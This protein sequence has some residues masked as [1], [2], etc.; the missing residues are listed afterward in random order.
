VLT[1]NHTVEDPYAHAY[2]YYIR[3]ISRYDRLWNGVAQ[4]PA[5]YRDQNNALESSTISKSLAN[6]RYTPTPLPGGLDFVL[7]RIQPL[8]EPTLL[9]SGRLD[10]PRPGGGVQPA[11][12]GRYWQV[13]VG[14]HPEQALTERNITMARMLAYRQIAWTLVREI[15]PGD[16][17]TQQDIQTLLKVT[18]DLQSTHNVSD[19][20]LPGDPPVP[21]QFAEP[22]AGSNDALEVQLA[23]RLSRFG[24]GALVLSW[25]ALPYYY[26]HRLL[27]IAQAANVVSNIVDVTQVAF[28]YVSPVPRTLIDGQTRGS[29]TT[30]RIRRIRI[31]LENYW[32]CLPSSARTPADGAP[33]TRETPTQ[34][35]WA[36]ENPYRIVL[37]FTF[38][39]SEDH[40]DPAAL[41]AV[42]GKRA[43]IDLST[44]PAT[45][46][47]DQYHLNKDESDALDAWRTDP[48]FSAEFKQRV[49]DLLDQLRNRPHR[50]FSSLVDPA[51][52]YQL[53]LS[54]PG[55]VVQVLADFRYQPA[56]VP[57]SVPVAAGF[58][59]RNFPTTFSTA[60]WEAATVGYLPYDTDPASPLDAYL[61][62][63]LGPKTPQSDTW[64][65]TRGVSSRHDLV[66]T[67]TPP[68]R[69]SFLSKTFPLDALLIGVY[70]ADKPLSATDVD[71]LR[72]ALL[73]A[74]RDTAFK[75]AVERVCTRLLAGERTFEEPVSV[76]LEALRELS[77]DA[78]LPTEA[79][80]KLTWTGKIE[81]DNR[82]MIE[83][84]RD[85][86]SPFAATLT[87]LLDAYDNPAVEFVPTGAHPVQSDVD[88]IPELK[89]A[90]QIVPP[91]TTGGAFR[92]VWKGRILSAAQEA[93][94]KI[95]EADASLDTEFKKAVTT[96]R[97]MIPK[98]DTQTITVD[99]VEADW[100]VRPG[101]AD[102][103]AAGLDDRI[104]IAAGKVAFRGLMTRDEA[105][106]LRGATTLAA[107]RAAL[108]ALYFDALQGGFEGAV[109]RVRAFRGSAPQR[110]MDV[111]VQF[112]A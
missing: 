24:E 99:V 55:N 35:R 69:L 67:P 14:R 106:L 91:K 86:L 23:P 36:I 71:A 63:T 72:S 89:P 49:T 53:I 82:A 43:T 16:V 87:A 29:S 10:G 57:P 65:S 20:S 111:S 32:N 78:V 83:L 94:L 15:S 76:G 77:K 6:L 21:T 85:K 90:L 9:F 33:G 17:A 73:T 27:L 18:Y 51:V 108:A 56:T 62:T 40:P 97:L 95:W 66:F 46:T 22:A 81:G 107:N 37:P 96:L 47:W 68:D 1:L 3:P 38:A 64:V 11:A 25:D 12:P 26:L 50:T 80:R 2:R 13:V 45:L 92:L 28:E 105:Q 93:K 101:Q 4:S 58:Q 104:L 60:P 79:A 44:N 31:R 74:P 109:L 110:T 52:V 8:A 61:E 98:S 5:L 103:I 41:G 19:P 30:D 42:L 7:P 54:R 70:T 100:H 88:L 84:W 39:K 59:V 102:L 75:L 48:K 112:D 34:E